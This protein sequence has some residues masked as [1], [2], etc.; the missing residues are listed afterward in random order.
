MARVSSELRLMRVSIHCNM[1]AIQR[2]AFVPSYYGLIHR[3]RHLDHSFGISRYPR[4]LKHKTL[5]C[6]RS[7][8]NSQITLLCAVMVLAPTSLIAEDGVEVHDA[9]VMTNT[10]R[11]SISYWRSSILVWTSSDIAPHAL[12]A[13]REISV[14]SGAEVVHLIAPI[15][16]AKRIWDFPFIRWDVV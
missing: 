15:D 1:V 9:E 7:W 2:A 16:Y 11:V 10:V 4:P 6:F 14:P 5:L 12:G 13:V 3:C 8:R